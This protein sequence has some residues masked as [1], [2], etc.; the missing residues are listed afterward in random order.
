[1]KNL[2]MA[3][4]M[5]GILTAWSTD[6]IGAKYC[7]IEINGQ[8]QSVASWYPTS[9]KTFS[10]KS[11]IGQC[12]T[13]ADPHI[14]ASGSNGPFFA[15][16]KDSYYTGI[17]ATF[18]GLPADARIDPTLSSNYIVSVN[19]SLETN[20][21]HSFKRH[22]YL[23]DGG[24]VEYGPDQGGSIDSSYH[25][26]RHDVTGTQFISDT[27][28]TD[29]ISV[30]Y[31]WNIDVGYNSWKDKEWIS[32][33]GTVVFA[34]FG[35]LPKVS[36]RDNVITCNGAIPT[37]RARTEIYAS[38]DGDDGVPG[39]LRLIVNS[40][41]T[42]DVKA[43][44]S[45]DGGSGIVDLTEPNGVLLNAQKTNVPVEFV[46]NSNVAGSGVVAVTAELTVI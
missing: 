35:T 12:L 42:Y 30:R 32:G 11:E 39:T 36:F 31:T 22:A 17:R 2:Y 44:G 46:V 15:N 16:F 7:A 27:E 45:L 41:D 33:S 9:P 29:R 6:S 4:V 20:T 26:W 40:P 5:F 21:G 8:W 38:T 43:Y 1:M 10:A 25:T 13:Q 14:T 23:I 37:C 18:D 3:I 28:S 19:Y 24:A 34:R